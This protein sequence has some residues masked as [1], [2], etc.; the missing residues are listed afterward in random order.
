MLVFGVDIPLVEVIF[1]IA[2]LII[3][4]LVEAVVMLFVFIK[5]M[6]KMKNVVTS[7]ENTYHLTS[8]AK[9]EMLER[10]SS[11]LERKEESKPESKAEENKKVE[12]KGNSK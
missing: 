7:L 2:V 5:Q 9:R 10:G 6:N 11:V 4:I 1:T 3:I 12:S 8:H